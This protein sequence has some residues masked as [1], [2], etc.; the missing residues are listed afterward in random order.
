MKRH[1]DKS[2]LG[3]LADMLDNCPEP[4]VTEEDRRKARLA[5]CDYAGDAT[6]ARD[7]LDVLGLLP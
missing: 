2:D 5:V 7:L 4:T 3:S 1:F 6:L